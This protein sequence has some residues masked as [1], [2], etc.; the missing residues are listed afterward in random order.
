MAVDAAGNIYVADFNNNE[1]RKIAPAGVVTSLFNVAGPCGV[2]LDTSGNFYVVTEVSSGFCQIA[3]RVFKITPVGVST[4]LYSFSSTFFPAIAV[5]T[6]GNVYIT[7]GYDIQKITPSG[8]VTILAGSGGPGTADGTGSAASF[9]APAGRAVDP[10][11]NVYVA[12]LAN[13]EIRKITP[14]GCVTTLVGNLNAGS[15]TG[16][17]PGYLGQPLSVALSPPDK[18]GNWNM[19]I[20]T[21]N[22]ITEILCASTASHEN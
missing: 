21:Q 1:I 10:E 7:N 19:V 5:D 8:V 2:T 3:D 15:F 11:G 14:A 4:S 22:L 13:N 20:S 6:A 17:L 12:D 9:N 16:S 18:F